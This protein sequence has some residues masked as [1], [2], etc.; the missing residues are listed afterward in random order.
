MAKVIDLVGT[1]TYKPYSNSYVFL[2]NT[3]I[4][5]MLSNKVADVMSNRLL[6]LCNNKITPDAIDN[7]SDT[8][9]KSIGISLSKVKSIKELTKKVKSKEIVFSKINKLTD[10]EIIK[11][12]TTIHGIGIWSAKMY[13]I[14]VLNKQDILPYEDMAF[15]QSF[16]WC[17]KTNKIDKASIDNKFQNLKPYRSIAS[18]Y[19]YKALDSGLT[20]RR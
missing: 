10:E 20:V 12:L 4:G 18:R 13:L 2:I 6:K 7:L 15:I 3:I 16:A 1:I 8:E 17:Y 5:Q 11:A 9:I 19:L 14:F